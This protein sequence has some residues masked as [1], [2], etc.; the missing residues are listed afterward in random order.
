MNPCM[1]HLI[2]LLLSYDLAPSLKL[3]VIRPFPDPACSQNSVWEWMPLIKEC[4]WSKFIP[5]DPGE[6][7]D[8]R[9]MV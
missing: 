3:L 7:I 6:E 4:V 1:L 8:L 9:N 5:E 2:M